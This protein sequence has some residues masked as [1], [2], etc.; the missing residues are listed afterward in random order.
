MKLCYDVQLCS[1]H[2]LYKEVNLLLFHKFELLLSCRSPSIWVLVGSKRKC[3]FH[4]HAHI[5]DILC[6]HKDELY[7]CYVAGF[8]LGL[9]N[10]LYSSTMMEKCQ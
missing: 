5:C 2:K 4:L 3:S 10:T 7:D 6:Y 9:R 8:F 1:L